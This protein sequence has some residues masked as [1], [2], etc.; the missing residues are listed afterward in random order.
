MQ[1]IG[2]EFAASAFDCNRI[3]NVVG[4]TSDNEDVGYQ[5]D[6]LHT[7]RNLINLAHIYFGSTMHGSELVAL[8]HQSTENNNY[9]E[10]N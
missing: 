2:I 3:S 5:C 7:G 8:T 10:A 4:T 1:G 6:P 9:M